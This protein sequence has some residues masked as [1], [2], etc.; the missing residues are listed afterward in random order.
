MGR[1][2]IRGFT[3]VELVVVIGIIALLAAILLPV[4]SSVREHGRSTT[5][6]SN[7]RQIAVAMSVYVGDS[8][9]TYPP[10]QSS[11]GTW[12]D[13]ISPPGRG[14]QL[15]CPD[16]QYPDLYSPQS[17]ETPVVGYAMNSLLGRLNADLDSTAGESEVRLR[18]PATTVT[19][20]DARAGVLALSRPD[21]G[22]PNR[23][24]ISSTIGTPTGIDEQ[25][26]ALPDGARRHSG[27][28]NYAFADE[29]VKW[30]QP[31]Q[32]LPGTMNPVTATSTNS[33]TAPAF[34]L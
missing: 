3:L 21:V 8:D 32:V 30:L 19:I 23:N 14:R 22:D 1:T 29:H 27:G 11:D 15:V 26:A 25:I 9:G 12:L 13:L 10:I 16:I 2:T 34:D 6:L 17:E 4:C 31:D 20:F 33:G 7:L 5:C 24:S 28:A 18:F